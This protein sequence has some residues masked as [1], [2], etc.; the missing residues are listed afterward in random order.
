[1]SSARGSVTV[2]LAG[3]M[4]AVLT[5][6]SIAIIQLDL[7]LARAR[8]N[9]AAETI[10]IAAADAARGLIGGV[11]CEVAG[12]LAAEFQVNLRHCS[13]FREVAHIRV[14]AL[15]FGIVIPHRI[16]AGVEP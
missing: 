7:L 2:L 9:R 1:M 3:L 15:S 10:A 11:P 14:D 5:V 13:V 4:T 12:Q 6:A 16:R 8:V